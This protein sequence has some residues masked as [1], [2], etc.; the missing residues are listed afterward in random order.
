MFPLTKIL[1]SSTFDKDLKK[2]PENIRK[3]F[4]FWVFQVE[5]LG[6]R[7]VRKYKGYHDEPLKGD[8][9]GQRSIRLNKSYRAIYREVDGEVEILML[10]VNKH[11]Y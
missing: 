2:I 4:I 3:K 7:E 5:S 9:R 10:E 11:D 1:R 6:V 8:R